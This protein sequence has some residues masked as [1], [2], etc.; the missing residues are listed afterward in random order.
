MT[1]DRLLPG[2]FAAALM[3]QPAS[4]ETLLHC[5]T[6]SAIDGDSIRCNGEN[7]RDMGDGAPH[8]SGYD[9]P[10]IG[11]QPGPQC[12]AERMLGQL[13]KV[14]LDELLGQEGV[15]VWDSGELDRTRSQRRLVWVRLPDGRSAGQVLINEGYAVEW[16][17]GYRADWCAPL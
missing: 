3:M 10:E 9:T 7:M 1:R 14:R 2:L 5:E 6:L 4:A 11:G 8:V 17:P 15:E 16:T 12:R 13:A